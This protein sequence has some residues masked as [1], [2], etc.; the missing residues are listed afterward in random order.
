[1]FRDSYIDEYIIFSSTSCD[2]GV[3][4]CFFLFFFQFVNAASMPTWQNL[5]EWLI[6]QQHGSGPQR[7][8][9]SGVGSSQVKWEQTSCQKRSHLPDNGHVNAPTY[10]SISTSRSAACARGPQSHITGWQS[11]RL[12]RGRLF[13]QNQA[14][15]KN[16]A[17]LNWPSRSVFIHKTSA[18]GH[19]SSDIQVKFKGNINM[20]HCQ[21]YEG[22]SYS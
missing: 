14:V 13:R 7:R 18:S 9:G 15:P 21:I 12:R 5:W 3:G 10:L 19:R 22:T 11:A 2:G 8:W 20:H 6:K 4:P 1:M 17:G 16:R